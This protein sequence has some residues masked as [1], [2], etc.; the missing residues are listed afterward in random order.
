MRHR[1]CQKISTPPGSIT[2]QFKVR[3]ACQNES[4]AFKKPIKQASIL[5][6]FDSAALFMA[7]VTGLVSQGGIQVTAGDVGRGRHS[8]PGS[9]TS[10]PAGAPR[11]LPDAHTAPGTARGDGKSQKH[12]PREEIPS[13]SQTPG[14]QERTAGSRRLIPTRAGMVLGMPSWQIVGGFCPHTSLS[15]LS[16][17]M[18]AAGCPS[19]LHTKAPTVLPAPQAVA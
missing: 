16:G 8:L 6:W 18:L 2:R 3:P 10:A 13:P 11:H 15:L 4:K 1:R 9:H 5:P 17:Q 19:S 12:L 14:S 7:E